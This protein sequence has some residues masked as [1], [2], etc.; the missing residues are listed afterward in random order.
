MPSKK[1]WNDRYN[2]NDIG[3][4][5]GKVSHPIK[6]W[7]DHESDI[8][9]K[10]LIPG[11]GRGFEVGYAYEIGFKNVYYLDFSNSASQ[12]FKKQFPNFPKSQIITDII[13]EQTFF[14]AISPNKRVQYI[15]KTF[16]LLK[17]NGKIIGLLFNINLNEKSPPFGGTKESYELLFKAKFD[18]LKIETCYN[19]V[20]PRANNELW[21]SM[22][23]LIK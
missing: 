9:K 3:W 17:K 23:K 19:S 18:I 12:K 11:A 4:D 10:I 8:S 16:E 5:I 1:Y 13:I 21:I 20:S 2:N 15:N 7:F 22:V 6:Q 14:C